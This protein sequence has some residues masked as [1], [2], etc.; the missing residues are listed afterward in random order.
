[1][2]FYSLFLLS[3]FIVYISSSQNVVVSEYYN[4]TGDPTGEWTEL[5][6]VTDNTSLVGYTLRDNAGSSGT[7]TQWTG[8]IRFKDHPLWRNLRAGTIIVINH[9]YT[10]YQN[11]DVDKRDGYIEIDAENETYFEKRCFSCILGPDWYNVALNIAQESEI[12]EIIDNNDNHVH[13]LAHMPNPSGS[14]NTMSEPKISAQGSITRSGVSVRV[15]PGRGLQAYNKGFDSMGEEATFS[16]DFVTKG[17]PNNRTSFLD[18]NQF[19]WRSLR[20]PIWSNPT[21]SAKVFRDSVSLSWGASVDPNPSDST[22]G[23]LILRTPLAQIN[24]SQIPIDG[25][26][27]N[28][29]DFL[30]SAL[31]VGVINSSQTT[32]FVD[33]FTLPCGEKYVYRVFAFR[34]RADDLHEDTREIYARGRSYNE[35]NYAEVQ[36]QKPMPPNPTIFA[37]EKKI[38]FCD[39]DSTKIALENPEH[40]PQ[41]TIFWLRDGTIIDSNRTEIFVNKTGNYK[42]KLTDSLGCFVFSNEI[43]ID[44]MTTPKLTILVNNKE[45]FQD[46][47]ITICPK[48]TVALKVYGWTSFTWLHDNVVIKE[49][50]ESQ[51][52]AE[53]AG[54]YWVRSTNDSCIGESYKVTVKL[55]DLSIN[56]SPKSIFVYLD[57]VQTSKDTIIT[58][59]N[60]GNDS[61]WINQIL[62]S[63]TAFQLI[64]P[65]LP[66]LLMPKS[67]INL[68][69]RFQPFRSGLF[70]SLMVLEKS[71]NEKDTIHLIGRKDP[72][73][74]IVSRTAVDFGIQ[75]YCKSKEIFVYSGLTIFNSGEDEVE[76]VSCDVDSSFTIVNPRFPFILPKDSSLQIIFQYKITNP[77]IDSGRVLVKFRTNN[78]LDSIGLPIRIETIE[79]TYEI[80]KIFSE[81]VILDECTNEA[82]VKILL[83]NKSKLSI[84]FSFPDSTEIIKCKSKAL[85]LNPFDSSFVEF[86]IRPDRQGIFVERYLVR[87][88]PCDFVDTLYFSIEKRG[89]VMKFEPEELDFGTLLSCN[90]DT[91]FSLKVT[92]KLIGIGNVTPRI[93]SIWID[94]PFHTNLTLGTVLRNDD[95][96]FVYLKPTS[97]GD[98]VGFLRMFISPCDK[99]FEIPIKAKVNFTTFTI[100]SSDVNFDETEIGTASNKKI[101]VKNKGNLPITVERIDGVLPP[102]SII[103]PNTYPFQIVPNDSVEIEIKFEPDSTRTYLNIL[104]LTFGDP[105]LTS[106]QIFLMGTGFQPSPE[107]ILIFGEEIRSRPF[108]IINI[109]VK[110]S[111]NNSKNLK[112]SSLSFEV[113]Y[114]YRLFNLHGI[115]LSK[116][117][118]FAD[119]TKSEG[120]IHF[121]LIFD[122]AKILQSE[123]IA[124]MTGMVMLGDARSTDF[125]FE[126]VQAIGS[127]PILVRSQ[128]GRLVTDSV[129]VI[130]LRLIQTE[131]IPYISNLVYDQ[132]YL[133]IT[134]SD[135]GNVLDLKITISNIIGD[136]VFENKLQL[137]SQLGREVSI[138]IDYLTKGVYFVNIQLSNIH[139]FNKII[140]FDF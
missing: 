35:Q 87:I 112:L 33:K 70:N 106:K 48:D 74:I 17:K 120:R 110:L 115:S 24:N 45:I 23:Y 114:N 93:D 80:R 133:K 47:S 4:V 64:S 79:P 9:R 104:N 61:I 30:G 56:F 98:Y 40:F 51:L 103:K 53:K 15:A 55:L 73:G 72:S 123:L 25:K 68:V 108:R 67:H 77:G 119:T 138:P 65:T 136:I 41:T 100:S 117:I 10:A 111:S 28:V 84:E 22:Q 137:N 13:A 131:K 37:I 21:L 89:L 69:I 94:F 105:C 58:L 82:V 91:T 97:S 125:T 92:S 43:L 26:I 49:G 126:N 113:L 90:P 130:D 44:V 1:M 127:E 39:Y 32:T 139:Y 57:K 81:P 118:I 60:T 86:I 135:I 78:I 76:I 66:I 129:C 116:S 29:G 121:H 2:K 102:F 132:N 52:I 5:L 99:T 95:E 19:Y 11:A 128:S 54:V 124:S 107:E 3:L 59:T 134:F 27:Y 85:S 6:V 140:R 42:V 109:P 36:V 50:R 62:Y 34:Y 63:D 8:G 14:W 122:S 101:V 7:P 16:P 83:V 88:S 18:Q 20:E 46:T 75:F 71:C 31:V 38:K 12:V 96:F